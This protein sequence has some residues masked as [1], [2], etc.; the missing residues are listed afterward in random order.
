MDDDCNI[1]SYSRLQYCLSKEPSIW[2]DICYPL[3]ATPNSHTNIRYPITN[4]DAGYQP[5]ELKGI[6]EYTFERITTLVS[7]SKQQGLV[8][9]GADPDD[10]L[11]QFRKQVA[12]LE[13]MKFGITIA[14]ARQMSPVWKGF[15]K[16]DYRVHCTAKDAV[17]L[18]PSLRKKKSYSIR[19]GYWS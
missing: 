10:C 9:C 6:P 19:L 3:V 17:K 11:Y 4:R 7:G 15:K 14:T 16:Y 2:L 5:V 13:W 8:V 18:A 1:T 12:L